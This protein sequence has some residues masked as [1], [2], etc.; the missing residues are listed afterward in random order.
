[1]KI[2]TKRSLES[3]DDSTESSK[4]RMLGAVRDIDILFTKFEEFNIYTIYARKRTVLGNDNSFYYYKSLLLLLFYRFRRVGGEIEYEIRIS[5][6][7]I[8][9]MRATRTKKNAPQPSRNG[10]LTPYTAVLYIIIVTDNLAEVRNT[11]ANA[12]RNDERMVKKKK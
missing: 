2:E 9:T 8:I 3:F 5:S 11:A 1:M 10:H 4:R 12:I 6:A 7:R